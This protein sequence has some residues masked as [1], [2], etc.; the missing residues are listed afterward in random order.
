MFVSDIRWLA[1][2]VIDVTNSDNITKVS[3]CDRLSPLRESLSGYSR[4]SQL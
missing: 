2:L 4:K 1:N 3:T